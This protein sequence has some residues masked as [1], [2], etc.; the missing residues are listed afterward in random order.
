MWAGCDSFEM[1]ETAL[2]FTESGFS[3]FPLPIPVE[4]QVSHSAG[5]V[6]S[7]LSPALTPS[8]YQ[9]KN[10]PRGISTCWFCSVN[11][12]QPQTCFSCSL[13]GEGMTVHGERTDVCACGGQEGWKG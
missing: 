10:K 11:K 1:D 2:P 7:A 9:I 8:F 13:H 4:E 12:H 6:S 5:C 3:A